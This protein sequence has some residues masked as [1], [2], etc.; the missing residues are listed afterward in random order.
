MVQSIGALRE[1]RS[2][3]NTKSKV[4]DEWC[5]TNQVLQRTY[6]SKISGKKSIRIALGES[7]PSEMPRQTSPN[8][9]GTSKRLVVEQ[10]T[11]RR[12]LGRP[13]TDRGGSTG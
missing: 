3:G 12:E 13:M 11:H 6:I 10:E 8:P 9:I 2:E 1:S 7:A 4:V 5:G